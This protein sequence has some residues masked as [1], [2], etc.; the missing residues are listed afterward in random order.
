MDF[1]PA[2]GD[3]DVMTPQTNI[4]APA[5]R[6]AAVIVAAGGGTRMGDG[7]EKQFR[8]LGGRSVLS[9]SV[10]A[11]LAHPATGRIVI[12]AAADR[13][14]DAVA[15]LGTLAEDDRVTIVAGGA[16]RQDSVAAGLAVA[17]GT[18]ISLVAIHDAAR[19]MLPQRV[20]TD[21]LAAL[22]GGA[23]AALPVLDV[24]DTMKLIK[25]GRVSGTI[26]RA[27]LGRAQTPQM[28]RLADLVAR[29]G[30][31]PPDSEITD[32]IRLF[33]D[34][35]ARIDTVTGDECLMKLT[36]PA[37]FAMLSALPDPE[38][39]QPMSTAPPAV[40]IRIG[41]GYDVHRFG[42]GDGPVRLGGIEIPH[43]RGL[44]AH[45]D[46]DVGLHAVCDAIFGAL[47]DGDIGSHFPPSD[48]RWKDAD[49]AQF[50]TFAAARCAEGGASI[51]HLD[52][53]LVCERPKIGPYR[54]AMRA[55]I[56]ALAGIDISRVAVKATTSERLGFTGREEGIAA[57]AT[58][59]L[60][61]TGHAA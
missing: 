3:K 29:L 52:L 59:T 30:S 26:E 45:S 35:T 36:R 13:K 40:D 39:G 48:D 11:F 61:M 41:N 31:L 37:D 51:L 7:L 12:V 14:A 25:G 18:G 55:R 22:D 2:I 6:L 49:S 50:L 57:Q 47:A 28:F 23:D 9:H 46:G 24:V 21:L 8:G 42:D 4:D 58:A 5:R 15:A 34:G 60:A 19:P 44:A 38:G 53:T 10:A 56:A 20:I 43:D 16:R 27:T 17:G 1:A 54:D 33:E 32:D